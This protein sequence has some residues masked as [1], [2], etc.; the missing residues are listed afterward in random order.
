MAG[1]RI[2]KNQ[3]QLWTDKITDG[4]IRQPFRGG[5]LTGGQVQVWMLLSGE[6]V[7]ETAKRRE[8]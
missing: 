7:I 3:I 2:V 5:Y 8:K 6:S 1:L 4:K